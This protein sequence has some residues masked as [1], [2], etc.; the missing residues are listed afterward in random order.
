M[1]ETFSIKR[2]KSQEAYEWILKKHYAHRIPSI[3]TGHCFGL[4]DVDKLV[5]VCT[6]GAPA[7]RN[8]CIG[9]CGEEFSWAVKELNRLCV[10]SDEINI[11]SWFVSKC[12]SYLRTATIIVSYA[13]T[14]MG[15]I[16]KI[17]QACNFLFTGTTKERT[18]IGSGEGK[19]S[20]HYDKGQDYSK[21]REQ[22]SAKHRYV[23]FCGSKKER[24]RFQNAL[25]YPILEYPKGETQ[26][27]D[28]SY[29]T[30]SQGIL[31]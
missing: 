11:T 10:D 13:D 4:Y 9:I 15:H 1:K 8:L 23:Y 30:T 26:R 5:G 17:Y 24:K 12:L 6:F 7:S 29:K 2:M 21:N 27:Y 22:R 14:S 16:G 3:A 19:H 25:K 31:F 18:D 28:A 20:R